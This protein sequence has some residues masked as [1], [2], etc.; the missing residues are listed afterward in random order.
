MPRSRILTALGLASAHLA[1]ADDDQSSPTTDTDAT[2]TVATT[3]TGSS[4]ADATTGTES[5]AADTTGC[6]EAACG[7]PLRSLSLHP[8][9]PMLGVRQ[10]DGTPVSFGCPTDGAPESWALDDPACWL[11][12]ID[13][14]PYGDEPTCS[15]Q[16]SCYWFESDGCTS[17]SQ[18]PAG[19]GFVE[20]MRMARTATVCG[21][22]EDGS[23]GCRSDDGST[24]ASDGPFDAFTRADC[25]LHPDGSQ[26][27]GPDVSGVG[28]GCTSAAGMYAVCDGAL[29]RAALMVNGD[30]LDDRTY[31]TVWSDPVYADLQYEWLPYCAI[32]VDGVVVCGGAYTPFPEVATAGWSQVSFGTMTDGCGIRDGAVV[33]WGGRLRAPE[34]LAERVWVG[35]DPEPFACALDQGEPRCWRDGG[36]PPALG[37]VGDACHV[38][39]DCEGHCIAGACAGGG[40]PFNAWKSDQLAM[41][42]DDARGAWAV[43]TMGGMLVRAGEAPQQ[44]PILSGGSYTPGPVGLYRI[45]EQE[46][47][48]FDPEVATDLLV[49]DLGPG[50]WRGLAVSDD[51]IV[52]C[53]QDSGDL[54]IHGLDGDLLE[55]LAVGAACN[56]LAV[57]GDDLAY[58]TY[59]ADATT[60]HHRSFASGLVTPI[61]EFPA[62]PINFVSTRD[63]T[64]YVMGIDTWFHAWGAPAPT[65]VAPAVTLVTQADGVAYGY[66]ASP[67]GYFAIDPSGFAELAAGAMPPLGPGDWFVVHEQHVYWSYWQRW[68]DARVRWAEFPE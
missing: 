41:V 65:A 29:V 45:D 47:H 52:A 10:P 46:V 62:Q 2:G 37:E 58:V 63:G 68:S 7:G 67:R 35:A 19:D 14:T 30:Y 60:I 27:C 13:C 64:Y 36:E 16:P 56:G 40:V 55:R 32:D 25:V 6:A 12:N 66:T 31:A 38:D 8:M 61:V 49:A 42:G 1:C 21:L 3:G 44:L 59:T 34:L 5:S 39:L 20:V 54:A 51:R 53:E 43:T 28:Q 4:A 48:A 50:I 11:A 18:V 15:A 23:V 9:S 57:Y 17:L 33:C 24:F 26:D 22:R